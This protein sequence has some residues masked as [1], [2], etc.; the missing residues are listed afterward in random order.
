MQARR[1]LFVG[2]V[3]AG[4]IAAAVLQMQLASANQ[5]LVEEGDT[6]SELAVRLGVPLEQLAAANGIVDPNF[7][8]AGQLL[9]VPVDGRSATEYL[10]VP[11]DTLWAIAEKVGVPAADIAKA[12]GL[13]DPDWVPAGRLLSVP[14]VGSTVTAG[15][16]LAGAGAGPAGTYTVRPGDDLSAIAYR[17]GVSVAALAEANGIVD[18]DFIV[19]GQVLTAS[20]TW[21]CPVPSGTFVNDYGY[22]RDDGSAHKGVDLFAETGAPILAPVGGLAERYPNRLGGLAVQ[23]YGNDGNR[24]YFAHLDDYGA[25]GRVVAGEVIGYVGDSGDAK[26]TSPHLHFEIH[27]GGGAA[28]INPFPSLVAACR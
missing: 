20:A 25:V 21:V 8:M 17:L 19:V 7:I 11:G 24:Y 1:L 6:L 13:V 23:L 14:G 27:P 15:G 5:Y 9:V 28:T 10:V 22:V 12:N 4:V 16:A 2:P 18:P 3:V 26:G